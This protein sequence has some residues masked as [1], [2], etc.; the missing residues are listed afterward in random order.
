MGTCV[1]GGGSSLSGARIQTAL[2]ELDE[3]LSARG[4]LTEE[5]DFAGVLWRR[6]RSNEEKPYW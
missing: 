4:H 1:V 3:L 6:S 2:N 5:R